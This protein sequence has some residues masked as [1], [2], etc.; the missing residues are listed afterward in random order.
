MR[1]RA[2]DHSGLR[3]LLFVDPHHCD[4]GRFAYIEDSIPKLQ[5]S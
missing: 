4:D 5:T 1:C 3:Y 2:D